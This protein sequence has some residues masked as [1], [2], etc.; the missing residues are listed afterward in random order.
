[1]K[2]WIQTTWK[3]P[4]EAV[5]DLT[6]CEAP[7]GG[8]GS[9]GSENI[10]DGFMDVNL[11]FKHIITLPLRCSLTAHCVMTYKERTAFISR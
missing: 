1:M 11:V 4:S 3:L 5:I 6:N 9:R 10:L 7:Q 2:L 8:I